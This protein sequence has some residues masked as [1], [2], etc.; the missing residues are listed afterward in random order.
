MAGY[1]GAM[2]YYL[3]WDFFQNE[4]IEGSE[5][6]SFQAGVSY[7]KSKEYSSNLTHLKVYLC[8]QN[9][10]LMIVIRFSLVKKTSF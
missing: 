6:N 4:F 2:V 5:G 1:V 9:I 8:L 10:F 3:F 7:Y